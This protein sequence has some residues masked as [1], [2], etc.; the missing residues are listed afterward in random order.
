CRYAQ[1]NRLLG[2]N[3]PPATVKKIFAGLS[4]VVVAD[5]AAGG[6]VEVPTFRVDLEREAD[7]IEEVCRIY[8][9][10][11]I[12]AQMLPA[13]P[14][15]SEFDGQWDERRRVRETLNALGFHEALNQTM[16]GEGALK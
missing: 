16:V 11:K 13:L 3:V 6:E 15:V 2:V 9:V 7:L 8:G 4:L 1:V 5:D 14:A 10:E 12:P